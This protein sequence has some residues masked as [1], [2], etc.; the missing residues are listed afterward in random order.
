VPIRLSESNDS[1]Q[2]CFRRS[3]ALTDR[4]LALLGNF[5]LAVTAGRVVDDALK[6]GSRVSVLRRSVRTM[7]NLLFFALVGLAGW[8]IYLNTPGVQAART[9]QNS[10]KALAAEVRQLEKLVEGA[11]TDLAKKID[12]SVGPRVQA[13]LDGLPVD[14]LQAKA[15][16]AR[17]ASLEDAG[18]RSVG[19]LY[20][21]SMRELC[22]YPN[23]GLVSARKILQAVE[24]TE[25]QVRQELTPFPATDLAS[26]ADR[27]IV[28]RAQ[29]VLVARDEIPDVV[30]RMKAELDDAD[31]AWQGVVTEPAPA[32]VEVAEQIRTSAEKLVAEARD[33]RSRRSDNVEV[34]R[35]DY[36]RRYADY[37][38]VIER[39]PFAVRRK[40]AQSGSA[41]SGIPREIAQAVETHPFEP[42]AL[43]VTLRRYQE[44]GAKYLLSQRRT[45]LGDEMGLGKTIEAL[46]AMSHVAGEDPNSRFLVVAPAGI[47]ENWMREVRKH[48][49]LRCL[50][51]YGVERYYG[52]Q[53]WLQEGGIGVTSFDTLRIKAES[54]LKQLGEDPI[55]FTVVDE[56]HYIKNPDA[57]RTQAVQQFLKRS[58]RACL[59]SGT[60]LMN[61]RSEFD[62]LISTVRPELAIKTKDLWQSSDFQKAIAP[63]YLRRNK[64]DVLREL[65]EKIEIE[66]WIE[67]SSDDIEAYRR[68]VLSRSFMT[69]RRAVT[70]GHG[71]RSSAKMR[72][73]VEI[74]DEYREDG[75]KV[76]V[77]SF[78]I[79]VLNA[80][81]SSFPTFGRIDGSVAPPERVR[82][83]QRFCETPGSA[84]LVSQID[85]GGVGLN[86]QGA[87]VVIL[88]EPQWNL[89][90]E[91][92]AIDRAHRMGQTSS[93]NVHRL[94]AKD[95][96][97]ERMRGICLEKHAYAHESEM[98]RA[99]NEA[100]ETQ[101]AKRVI[102]A[103]YERLF[104]RAA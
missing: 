58:D 19:E 57:K 36:Q 21:K 6:H 59:M 80:V 1:D 26:T 14:S 84:V 43:A 9:V 53:S 20:G 70:L 8:A 66:D 104:P 85:A 47:V 10:I 86:L 93:V 4:V 55:E 91:N 49:R 79:D 73:L 96:V 3:E 46:A 78:F 52:F 39:A 77:F 33:A 98:N 38:A 15:S 24:E 45:I 72:R 88:M 16:G 56:A 64:E 27:E 41:K 103:E 74:L 29:A 75:R 28:G 37:C 35:D 99:S 100:T 40:S 54:W 25:A 68:A 102:D 44:L 90:R 89:A 31:H 67:I 34:L 94:L 12:E 71:D 5:V 60:P 11:W 17:I 62:H 101:L 95:S 18:V 76:L 30:D 7:E 32:R 22:A 48:T 83:A 92:Q 42:R 65:P 13:K 81:E 2:L 23:I 82:L 61:H 51:L 87:S 63:V 69:M 97:D 50:P